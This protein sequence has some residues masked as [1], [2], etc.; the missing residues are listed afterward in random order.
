MNRTSGGRSRR[1]RAPAPSGE[2]PRAVRHSWL[3]PAS[4]PRPGA[5][6]RVAGAGRPWGHVSARLEPR[7]SAALAI[8]P[9]ALLG[10][11]LAP[12]CRRGRGP[13]RVVLLL[14]PLPPGLL[15]GRPLIGR[16][17][18]SLLGRL[19]ALPRGTCLTFASVARFRPLGRVFAALEHLV[20]F[21]VH[22][23]P[24]PQA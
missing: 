3:P 19:L 21:A 23:E 24:H 14:A 17:P 11:R 8:C 15:E 22:E 20:S 18:A 4:S 5:W 12:K 13:R 2:P 10:H 1:K 6:R 7:G 9:P 16:P